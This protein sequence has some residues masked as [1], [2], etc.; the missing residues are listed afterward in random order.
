MAL[1]DTSSTAAELQVSIHRRF[2]AAE[3][4]QMAIEMSEF[5][6][7]LSRQGVRTRLPNLTEP[8]VDAELLKQ[9]YGFS[10]K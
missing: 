4:L 7:A 3:R 2:S 1:K 8:E 10:R 9:M 5:T 6:R